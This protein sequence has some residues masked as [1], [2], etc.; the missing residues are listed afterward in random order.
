MY[1]FMAMPLK[2][3]KRNV[4]DASKAFNNRKP[5]K[6]MRKP[7]VDLDLHPTLWK[8]INYCRI[9][10]IRRWYSV[11]IT[12]FSKT[13]TLL[14]LH[15]NII[16]LN[17]IGIAAAHSKYGNNIEKHASRTPLCLFI[18]SVSVWFVWISWSK[19]NYDVATLVT[20]RRKWVF[21]CKQ[22]FCRRRLKTNSENRYTQRLKRINL[23]M[24]KQE[25]N[26]GSRR[27]IS[28]RCVHATLSVRSRLKSY[29]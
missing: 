2:K 24:T 16:Q 5:W 8:K 25:T 12:F 11:N 19:N 4:L 3:I 10:D 26:S 17:R 15:Q 20:I 7:C 29:T 27:I 28:H 23:E 6:I 22:M 14:L 9:S 13:Q 18:S 21:F 1:W